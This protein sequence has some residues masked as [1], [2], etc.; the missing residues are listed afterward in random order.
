[1]FSAI[2][3]SLC[4]PN[5]EH[6]TELKRPHSVRNSDELF[7]SGRGTLYETSDCVTSFQNTVI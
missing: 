4:L 1:M 2:H 7:H 5:T 3:M 6:A